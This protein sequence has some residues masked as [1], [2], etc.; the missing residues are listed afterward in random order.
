VKDF[1][2]YRTV[3]RLTLP[4]IVVICVLIAGAVPA[5]A[6]AK[7]RVVVGFV[8]SPPPGFQ[9]VLLNVQAVRIN[10][11]NNPSPT[12]G[13]WQ[14]IPTPPGIGGQSQNA[15]LQIDL[16]ATQNIPQ[17]FNTVGVKPNTYRTA[18]LL[19][20]PNN[21][22][23]LIPNCPQSPPR[24]EGCINYPISLNGGNLISVND[25]GSNGL[26]AP[27]KGQLG[28][29]M[30]QLQVMVN[31]APTTPGG[32]FSVTITLNTVPPNSVQGIVTGM[33]NVNHGTGGSSGIKVRALGVTAEAIGTNTAIATSGVK[34]GGN[35]PKTAVG[36][37]TLALPAAGGIN[38]SVNGFG[39]LYDLAVAGGGDTYAA[40]RLPPLYPG[41]T[42]NADFTGTTNSLT[43]NQTLGNITGQ[44]IDGCA[45]GGKTGVVGATLELLIPP[46]NNSGA[47]CMTNPEQCVTVAT[48]N[49][50]NTGGFPL[51][52]ALLV[53]AE[54]NNV[55]VLPKSAPYVMKVTAP[56][57]DDLLVLTKPS[58]QGKNSGG[59][60]STDLGKTFTKCNLM[61]NRGTITGTI[62]ITP[63]L[64]GQTTLV[65][66]F[67]EDATTNNV[68]SAL[69]MP[70][71]ISG[72]NPGTVNFTLNVPTANPAQTS[73]TF[74]LFATTIDLYQGLTD[75][76]QGHTVAVLSGVQ[77]PNTTACTT[78][79]ATFPPDQI[80]DCIGHGSITGQVANANLGTSV[81]LSK[82]NVQ[83][84]SSIVENQAPLPNSSNNYSF[85]IPADT[86]DVQR[87]QLPEPS[88]N[89]TPLA[90][91]TPLPDG[92]LTSVTIPPAPLAGGARPTPTPAIKCPTTCSNP[93]GSCPGIC[94]NTIAP[95]L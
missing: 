71:S 21:P 32:P 11:K 3:R 4:L 27:G 24:L 18:E 35:C 39:T 7:A 88:P 14:R 84:N 92:P 85:C 6:A 78:A 62:P 16:N 9:N 81:V 61:M 86:Y 37:F 46:A 25:S 5:R 53:P 54:F 41:Q 22:G 50:N 45:T 59:T 10:P 87:F 34:S 57:Y 20:D 79:T 28:V 29:L 42:L 1:F 47:N 36:C 60:C 2:V 15:E 80:I 93:D 72:S 55:P 38:A 19:L 23:V 65:Q 17:L 33:V 89:M 40:Q 58:S 70:V 74:D 30:L 12:G 56:G 26:V 94:N 49:T 77:I 83:L 51:P 95:I 48:A 69:P 90:M 63:P 52:G 76:Y 66:V 68:K 64:P 43:E 67:A 13:G 31:Q 91:P 73:R 75:P 8:G 82:Q 44:V